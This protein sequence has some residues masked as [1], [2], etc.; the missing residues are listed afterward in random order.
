MPAAE[1]RDPLPRPGLR[2]AL[3]RLRVADLDAFQAY[4]ADPVLGLYQGWTPMAEDAARAFLAR[5]AMQPFGLRGEWLQLGIADRASDQLIGDIGLCLSAPG[6]PSQAELGFTLAVAWQGRGL[7]GEA[8]RVALTLL[9]G[10]S[11]IERAVAITDVRN[12]ASIRLLRAVG[13]ELRAT[14]AAIF[15]GQ[16][17]EE[18][19]YEITRR[20]NAGQARAFP[21]FESGA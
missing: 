19:R 14:E 3:R 17:C 11:D 7:A 1:T 10:H 12:A 8:V 21:D 2:I 5:M 15:R 16:A 4:R 20:A 18:Q 9:F 6:R 13:M